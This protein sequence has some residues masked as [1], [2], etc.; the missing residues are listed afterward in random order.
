M[1]YV[2]SSTVPG[3]GLRPLHGAVETRASLQPCQLF[4]PRRFPKPHGPQPE[5]RCFGECGSLKIRSLPNKG[6]RETPESEISAAALRCKR[7]AGPC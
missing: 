7:E 5:E 1:C 3:A 2:T 6:E 4:L